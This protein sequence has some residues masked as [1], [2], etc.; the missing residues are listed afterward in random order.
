MSQPYR[1]ALF[2]LTSIMALLPLNIQAQPEKYVAG[3]NYLVLENPVRTRDSSK[4]EVVELFWYGCSHYYHFEP[5]IQ[6]WKKSQT[7]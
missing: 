7:E 4:V 3:T 2:F 1:I 5:L 6:Q